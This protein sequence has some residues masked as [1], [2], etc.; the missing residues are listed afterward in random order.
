MERNDTGIEDSAKFLNESRLPAK[1]EESQLQNEISSR[2]KTKKDKKKSKKWIVRYQSSE[3]LLKDDTDRGNSELPPTSDGKQSKSAVPDGS[4]SPAAEGNGASPTISIGNQ[5]EAPTSDALESP[6]KNKGDES[7][8]ELLP[9]PNATI[10]QDILLEIPNYSFEDAR[11]RRRAERAAEAQDRE[12]LWGNRLIQVSEG[13]GSWDISQEIP[14]SPVQEGAADEKR[15]TASDHS[16]KGEVDEKWK[17]GPVHTSE[18]KKSQ[19]ILSRIPSSTVKDTEDWG[20]LAKKAKK[21][22]K[23][24]ENRPVE[25]SGSPVESEENER[26][27]ALLAFISKETGS[28]IPVRDGLGLPVKDEEDAG[29]SRSPSE[30]NEKGKED[31]T[32]EISSVPAKDVGDDGNSGLV[33]IP[34]VTDDQGTL[35]EIPSHSVQLEEDSSTLSVRTQ[36]SKKVK[37]AKK[38]LKSESQRPI[39]IIG[40]YVEKPHHEP[41]AP[42][43]PSADETTDDDHSSNNA[44]K[45]P[46][47]WESDDPQTLDYNEWRREQA[48]SGSPFV[49]VQSYNE[50]RREEAE[51]K[52]P[53]PGAVI[54]RS[55]TKEDEADDNL[56]FAE[57]RKAREW[58]ER[59]RGRLASQML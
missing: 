20:A 40:M 45:F 11:K 53:I 48:E 46:G 3:S 1:D 12:R 59:F 16:V 58:T 8:S 23:R 37:K 17:T 2:I 14:K 33:L 57:R 43:P 15:E 36:K 38:K 5:I 44:W 41:S 9:M 32:Q 22:K 54:S 28:K 47:T 55:S 6:G 50:W 25:T 39:D 18:V 24:S 35:P 34:E 4:G 49:S 27:G 13:K 21:A 30:S 56:S 29:N 31:T 19:E 7:K 52:S 51:S 42:L 26:N 10:S